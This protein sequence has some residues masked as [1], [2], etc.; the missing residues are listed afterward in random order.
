MELWGQWDSVRIHSTDQLIYPV[1]SS[2][3]DNSYLWAR[4]VSLIHQHL[5]RTYNVPG[6]RME[7][8]FADTVLLNLPRICVRLVVL[9]PFYSQRD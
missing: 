7:G 3:E 4:L 9:T 6:S 8:W 5:L 2:E 1:V